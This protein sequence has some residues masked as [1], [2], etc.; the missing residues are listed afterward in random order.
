MALFLLCRGGD[1]LSMDSM[2]C[3]YLAPQW[4]FNLCQKKFAHLIDACFVDQI[5]QFSF[6]LKNHKNTVFVTPNNRN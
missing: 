5:G 6:N 3:I 2:V 4:S 1:V